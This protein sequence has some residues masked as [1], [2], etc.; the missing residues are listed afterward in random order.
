[1]AILVIKTGLPIY[2][3]KHKSIKINDLFFLYIKPNY[4]S[5]D[6]TE[7]ALAGNSFSGEDLCTKG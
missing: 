3:I 7:M 6:G 5:S 2:Q 4:Y 1:M